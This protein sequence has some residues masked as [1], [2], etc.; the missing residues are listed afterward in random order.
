MAR[1]KRYEEFVNEQAINEEISFEKIKKAVKDIVGP[2]FI[3]SA[4]ASS[5]ISCEKPQDTYVYKYSYEISPGKEASNV[6]AFN[7]MLTDE[8]LSEIDNK[9]DEIMSDHWSRKIDGKLEFEM[10]DPDGG[11]QTTTPEEIM[12]K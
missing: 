12:R 7:R 6:Y 5:L 3:G 9:A 8:E 2:A 10:V 4:L 1:I 11:Y